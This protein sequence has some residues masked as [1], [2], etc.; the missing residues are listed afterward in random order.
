MP[1]DKTFDERRMRDDRQSRHQ[2][3]ELDA[4]VGYVVLGRSQALWSGEGCR[5]RPGNQPIMAD[6]GVKTPVRVWTDSSAALGISTRSGL[7][8]MCHLEAHT[9]W[10]LEKVRTGA[11]QVRKGQRA[12]G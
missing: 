9:L 1:E 3:L 12:P 4:A 5:G 2:G 11:I 6:F 7:V 10:V 8:E